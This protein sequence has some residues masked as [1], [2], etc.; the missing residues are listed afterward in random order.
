MLIAAAGFKTSAA[1]TSPWHVWH[2]IFF[3]PCLAW[4]K[5]TKSG[6]LNTR[7]EGIFASIDA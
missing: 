7:D 1:H 4:L 6:I 5:K 2:P 3:A